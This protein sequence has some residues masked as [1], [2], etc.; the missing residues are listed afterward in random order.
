M[1]IVAPGKEGD[2]RPSVS[3]ALVILG[4]GITF[5]GGLLCLFASPNPEGAAF[6]VAA[7]GLA[8][9]AVGIVLGIVATTSERNVPAHPM[10]KVL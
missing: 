3:S 4:T 10:A 8:A 6:V 9:I 1:R 5:V 2:Q 7:V